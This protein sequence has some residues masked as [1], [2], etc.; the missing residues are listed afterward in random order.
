[1]ESF[2]SA[3]GRGRARRPVARLL[4]LGMAAAMAV[5]LLP[6]TTL[7]A[8]PGNGYLV[9]S[10]GVQTTPTFTEIYFQVTEY[11]AL[12]ASTANV[13]SAAQLAWTISGPAGVGATCGAYPGNPAWLECEF[14]NTGVAQVAFTSLAN[15]VPAPPGDLPG[16][17][18]VTVTAS[19]TTGFT[20]LPSANYDVP[21]L[22]PPWI[23]T[24]G[25]PDN[26]TVCAVDP[27]G[28]TITTYTG[29][30]RFSS[31]D[32]LATLPA[33]Y[34]FVAADNGCHTFSITFGSTGPR[35]IVVNDTITMS[36]YGINWAFVLLP[37][38]YG[39]HPLATPVRMLDTRNGIGLSGKLQ[40]N[41]GVSFPVASGTSSV[42][43]CAVA[44]TGNLTVVN[45]TAGWAVYLG[46]TVTNTPTTSAINFNAG[47]VEGNSLTVM[48]NA[49]TGY[50]AAT[51]ISTAGNTT[52]LVFDV[53]GYYG[54]M[55]GSV[56]HSLYTPVRV[57]DTR[58]NFGFAGKV[59][60]GLPATFAV[61]GGSA[62]FGIPSSATAVTGNLTVV[63]STCGWAAYLG[64]DPTPIPATSS[65]NFVTGQIVGNGVT[66][67]LDGSG[68]NYLSA[69]YIG[70][71]GCTTDLVFDVTGYYDHS[72]NSNNG[73]TATRG[74]A[75]IPMA[76]ARVLDTRTSLG[77]VGPAYA[78]L[79][80]PFQV[81]GRV[82]IPGPSFFPGTGAYAVTGNV[83][84]V[85]A[86][87]GWALYLGAA[88]LAIPLTSNINFVAGEVRG[89]GTTVGLHRNDPALAGEMGMLNATYISSGG[90]TTDVIFDATGYFV[91]PF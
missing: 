23:E 77:A 46:P 50:V 38:M 72:L 6:G 79:P 32:P 52:D 34:T 59:T 61:A 30:I 18:N 40:A 1:M 42:P 57:L 82:G 47:V 43:W 12:N 3:E 70:T 68:D 5:C 29:T 86:T 87:A 41:V 73:N 20:I 85:N 27:A 48:I 76:P 60:A 10:P 44:V 64:P 15:P 49:T 58:D 17:L 28:N 7:A 37:D 75:Y 74:L 89:N 31:S 63:N 66:V 13:M 84:V 21:P 83:T 56:F 16:T 22:L 81:A 51:Y 78:N 33:N 39:Y 80:L 91:H 45:Q 65:V 88:P 14:I 55:G 2:R 4:A 8:I 25:T 90:N 62:G 9:V 69:T 11:D 36:M 53:T 35:S 67:A 26:W 71:P 54:C 24:V 19:A